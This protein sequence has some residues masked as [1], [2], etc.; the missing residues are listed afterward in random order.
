MQQK[1]GV[2]TNPIGIGEMPNEVFE[3]AKTVF[4]TLLGRHKLGFMD[5]SRDR[6]RAVLEGERQLFPSGEFFS[7]KVNEEGLLKTYFVVP[8]TIHTK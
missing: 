7:F 4:D 8:V 3:D 6:A 5:A 2:M 1:Q